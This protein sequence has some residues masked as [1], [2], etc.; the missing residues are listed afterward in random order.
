MIFDRP[1]CFG[2]VKVVLIR[3][4]LFWSRPNHFGHV[5]SKLFWTKFYNLDLSKMIWT[6]QKRIGPVKNNRYST[7]II[8]MVQNYLDGPKSFWTIYNIKEFTSRYFFILNS[9]IWLGKKFYCSKGHF[10]TWFWFHNQPN[11][12]NFFVP[13][14][15]GHAVRVGKI[16][17][18]WIN[19]QLSKKP[20]QKCPYLVWV[21]SFQLRQM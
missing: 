20:H 9:P 5:Q 10:P 2:R 14:T 6:R 19:W 17:E 16:K 13:T 1:N 8:W 18:P 12:Q 11:D 3:S 7:K 15:Q 4:K 21:Y